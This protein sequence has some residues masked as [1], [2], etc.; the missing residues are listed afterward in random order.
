MNKIVLLTFMGLMFIISCEDT[1]KLN[2]VE[3]VEDASQLI[4]LTSEF[5]TIN[6][7]IVS[8]IQLNIELDSIKVTHEQ[9]V[10]IQTD[11]G[12]LSEIPNINGNNTRNEITIRSAGHKVE[13]LIII[14]PELNNNITIAASITSEDNTKYSVNKKIYLSD[15]KPDKITLSLNKDSLK[16]GE[17]GL[18][19][20]T[21]QSLYGRVSNN[22]LIS[23]ASIL[24]D[25]AVVELS[26][27]KTLSFDER[28]YTNI[29]NTNGKP[30]LIKVVGSYRD[31]IITDTLDVLYYK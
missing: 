23:F 11:Y 13:A 25:S 27:N 10:L 7:I 14:E 4:Y 22:L 1:F 19:T 9:D 15:F 16:I 26:P 12:Y 28:V 18:I 31:N 17:N 5:D 20:G 29:I 8:Q 24:T 6:P 30:G 3:R 21:L 2:D